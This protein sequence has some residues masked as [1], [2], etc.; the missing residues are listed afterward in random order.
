MTLGQLVQPWQSQFQ[1][2]FSSAHV[3]LAGSL[4]IH[5]SQLYFPHSL[6]AGGG[7]GGGSGGAFPCKKNSMINSAAQVSP[8]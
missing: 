2:R 1:S 6:H 4:A 3:Y 5:P 7:N 8:S